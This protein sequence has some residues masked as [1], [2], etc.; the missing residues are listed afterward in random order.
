V[1]P[2]S[3][4]L[5]AVLPLARAALPVVLLGL[6]VALCGCAA[7]RRDAAIGGAP[8]G[9]AAGADLRP[10]PGAEPPAAEV[11]ADPPP[12][13]A[14]EPGRPRRSAPPLVLPDVACSDGLSCANTGRDYELGQNGVLRDSPRALAY[15]LKACDL[16]EKTGCNNYGYMILNGVGAPADLPRGL[17]YLQKACDLGSGSG[18]HNLGYAYEN[19]QGV[20]RDMTVA[21]ELFRKSCSLGQASGC[22]AL[23]LCYHYGLGLDRDPAQAIHYLRIGCAGGDPTGCEK[24]RELGATP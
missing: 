3:N 11:A 5:L 17:A 18:C 16:D 19:E 1:T 14:P 8:R 12:G 9:E 21:A 20:S 13:D 2:G 4:T 22:R 15:Y 24:L 6:G 10:A 7:P 23:G